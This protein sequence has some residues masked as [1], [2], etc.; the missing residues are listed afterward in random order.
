M[1]TRASRR[2]AAKSLFAIDRAGG[3]L[4]PNGLC[5]GSVALQT[6]HELVLACMRCCSPKLVVS[7]IAYGPLTVLR[8]DALKLYST[9]NEVHA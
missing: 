1:A 2:N 4:F 5:L 7:R 3:D 6:R 8:R 9:T